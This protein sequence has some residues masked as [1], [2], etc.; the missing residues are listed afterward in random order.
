MKP[1]DALAPVGKTAGIVI[2][3]ASDRLTGAG[4]DKILVRLPLDVTGR[5]PNLGSEGGSPRR[6]WGA[7]QQGHTVQHHIDAQGARSKARVVSSDA[8][9]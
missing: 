9:Q 1:P 5:A 4:P 8:E 7:E 2:R 6:I 3:K